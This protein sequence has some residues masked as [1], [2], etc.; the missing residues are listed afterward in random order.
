MNLYRCNGGNNSS[1]ASPRLPHDNS[2]PLLPLHRDSKPLPHPCTP[3]PPVPS[4]IASQ[5]AAFYHLTC[6]V[7]SLTLGPLRT[8]LHT[9]SVANG[10]QR[11]IRGSV[12][13]WPPT[14]HKVGGSSPALPGHMLK[15][16][17]PKHLTLNHLF[18]SPAGKSLGGLS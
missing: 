13:E 3:F 12:A 16:P 17:R 8:I 4:C 5:Q 11:W 6:S 15:C 2:P 18:P 10:G 14:D 9:R 7:Q 1:Q